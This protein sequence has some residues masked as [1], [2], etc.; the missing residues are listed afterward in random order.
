[1]RRAF[2]ISTGP[3]ILHRESTRRADPETSRS[4]QLM[5][6]L[7]VP[8]V[9]ASLEPILEFVRA[10][11]QAAGLEPGAAYHLE[12]AVDEIATNI[13]VHGYEEAGLAGRLGITA[14][15]DDSSLTVEII[16]GAQPYDPRQRTSPPSLE[17]ALEDR[18]VG[19]LGVF[20]ALRSVD[21]FDYVSAGGRNRSIFVMKR[22]P[23]G[24]PAAP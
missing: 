6:A 5:K 2:E 23:A 21:H 22:R 14:R 10:A 18:P 20:L 17:A 24:P 4:P 9:R 12:L 16:D 13:V 3:D 19:G 8:G 15:W 11:A 1:M 7:E